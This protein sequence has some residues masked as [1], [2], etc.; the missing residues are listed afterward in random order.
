M[1]RIKIEK[2]ERVSAKTRKKLWEKIMQEWMKKNDVSLELN[3]AVLEAFWIS[4]L[5]ELNQ[6]T[7]RK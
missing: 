5:S 2:A 7:E 6:F 3:K 4:G 1:N